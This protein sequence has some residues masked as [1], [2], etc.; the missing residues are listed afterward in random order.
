MSNVKIIV[1]G[2]LIHKALFQAGITSELQN[3]RVLCGLDYMDKSDRE[4][5]PRET[6]HFNGL[7]MY[8]IPVRRKK[9]R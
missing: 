8:G 6:N 2:S 7:N 5:I 1:L 3:G 9:G 4:I